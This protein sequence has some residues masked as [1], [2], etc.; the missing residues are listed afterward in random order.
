MPRV[1][2]SKN[3]IRSNPHPHRNKPKRTSLRRKNLQSTRPPTKKTEMEI[4]SH[5]SCL[6][7]YGF[8]GAEDVSHIFAPEIVSV[9]PSCKSHWASVLLSKEYIVTRPKAMSGSMARKRSQ[10][11]ERGEA[12]DLDVETRVMLLVA[13]A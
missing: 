5:I 6:E 12:V 8:D 9:I 7:K 1:V 4:K 3:S 2:P 13:V 11:I 10:S